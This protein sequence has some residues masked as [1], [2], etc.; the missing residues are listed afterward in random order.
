[1]Y[2]TLA[3]DYLRPP[4]EPFELGATDRTPSVILKPAQ[5]LFA[6]AG[7]SIPENADRFYTPLHALLDNYGASPA[8][9]TTV[10][11]ALSYFN[12]SSSKYLLDLFRHL[13][14]L[15]AAGTTRVTLEW[16]F[17]R[18][19]LDMQEAGQDY[20]SLLEFPVRLVENK[21]AN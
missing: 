21:E 11:V 15:H 4:M 8:T 12:S 2:R 3:L 18:G 16:H 6:L 20:R 10:R 19:D 5:G 7:C 13:E 14:D 1:M 17:N 9:N